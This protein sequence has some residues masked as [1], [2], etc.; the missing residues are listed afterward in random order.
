MKKYIF[1]LFVLL[2]TFSLSACQ[3]DGVYKVG[4]S[5]VPHK[6][7]LE[8]VKPIL[9]AQGY[10]FE[11]VEFNDYV[12]PNSTLAAG[13]IIANFFQHIPYLNAQ[14]EEYGYDF[15]NVGGVH[16]EPIG[17]Y[18]KLYESIDALPDDL[19]IIISNSPTDRPRLLGVL[20]E[21]GLIN[22]NS[23]VTDSDIINATVNQLPTL[24]TS[25]YHMTFIEVAAELLY[26][27]YNHEEGDAVL[28]NGNFALDNGLNPIEDSIALEGSAS[29]YV[30]ILV[31]TTENQNDPFV[32]ALIEALQSEEVQQW[33]LDHYDGAVVP[34]AS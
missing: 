32:K 34:A 24:F 14:I 26:A 29:R 25:E 12:L 3:D 7:I 31:T 1:A 23:D 15:T 17:L 33:I 22:I 19:E 11:I 9:E 16:V 4:A 5:P 8:H 21:N 18:S 28:I 30:N 20:D 27:N 10:T 6:E 13:E 2:I